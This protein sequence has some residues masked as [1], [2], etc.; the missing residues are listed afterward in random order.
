MNTHTAY[1]HA[2]GSH[3]F[4]DISLQW[5]VVF[6]V[7]KHEPAVVPARGWVVFM[8]ILAVAYDDIRTQA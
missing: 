1:P 8:A 4:V 7:Y 6:T 5:G 3:C 2:G